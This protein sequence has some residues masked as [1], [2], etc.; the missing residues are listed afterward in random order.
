MTKLHDVRQQG[1]SIWLDYIRRSML[2]SG[3]LETLIE[4]GLRGMTS[5]PTI[6][7]AAI[8]ESDEYDDAIRALAQQ[9]KSSHEIYETVAIEDVQHAADLFRP[10][11]EDP[12]APRLDGY[13]SLEANPH[14][15]HDVA[16]TVE[17]IRRLHG[18]VDR[19]NV[20][21][22]VPATE[23]GI[24]AIR[25]LIDEGIS[26]NATLI[27]SMRHYD[28]VINAY[29]A[30]LHSRQSRDE[31]LDHIA[32]VASLFVSRM[33][34]KL[35]P[36]LHE[37]GRGELAGQ[38]GIANARIVYRRFDQHFSSARWHR[39]RSKG[40]Q[41]Q[42]LLWGS[43]ST[44]NPDY[45]DTMYVDKLIG[46]HTVNTVPPETLHA[47]MDHGTVDTTLV[48]GWTDAR[49][50][51]ER[52]AKAGID[53]IDVGDELQTEGVDKFVASYDQLIAAIERKRAALVTS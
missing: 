39:L 35:D 50:T 37:K 42:R 12:E 16:G 52:L 40:A 21:F 36:R 6:F 49:T 15:A 47:F 5:N 8:A 7:H 48:R 25:Q 14:L 10:I 20:M 28:R 26:I 30:A 3:E 33:D 51:M 19:P 46:P 2:T 27:F 29:L 18:L 24:A 34:G 13:V 53:V 22:K 43:T 32:S 38:V 17:E 1:Q 9:G 45:P 41:R 23:P 11:Y 31:P 4:Q 44:K